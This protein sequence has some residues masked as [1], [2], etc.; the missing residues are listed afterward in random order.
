MA[1]RF[2]RR[3]HLS[4][5][6]EPIYGEAF[7]HVLVAHDNSRAYNPVDAAQGKEHAEETT[8]Y[9]LGAAFKVLVLVLY[10]AALGASFEEVIVDHGKKSEDQ[11]D[12]APIRRVA[13]TV[14]FRWGVKVANH[15]VAGVGRQPIERFVA[16]AKRGAASE[17][18]RNKEFFVTLEAA[19]KLLAAAYPVTRLLT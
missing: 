18:S 1:T 10:A 11:Q 3:P 8:A 6:H 9:G 14:Y 13:V 2:A 15:V 5:N 17:A 12:G 16:V 4:F 19:T 7:I